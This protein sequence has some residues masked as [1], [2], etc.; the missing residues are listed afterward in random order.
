MRK[1]P[2]SGFRYV[3]P[4]RWIGKEL[5][6]G[7][8]HG[9]IDERGYEWI[10]GPNHHFAREIDPA[11]G[12]PYTF[13][14][15]VQI[16]GGNYYNISPQYGPTRGHGEQG[17][18]LMGRYARYN[19]YDVVGP[20]SNGAG[21]SGVILDYAF[22]RNDLRTEVEYLVYSMG[23]REW[24]PESTV[25]KIG[26]LPTPLRFGQKVMVA[27]GVASQRFKGA[28]V[29]GMAWDPE[30][31]SWAFVVRLHE[32]GQVTSVSADEVRLPRRPAASFDATY[33]VITAE[34]KRN[35]ARAL[36]KRSDV[37]Y[38]GMPAPIT[39]LYVQIG[40]TG[41]RTRAKTVWRKG[42]PLPAPKEDRRAW[43]LEERPVAKAGV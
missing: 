25:E 11:S 15:D 10:K 42:M 35:V 3:K 24:V 37:L 27:N 43:L 6:R 21:P 1:T 2:P 17:D 26:E 33:N 36:R 22:R 39:G 12:K 29:I 4:H 28:D 40:R 34:A 31:D 19:I 13:E 18:I 41:Q 30:A 8:E 38:A 20:R 23:S 32:N 16:G 7:P 14:W 9:F 5:P